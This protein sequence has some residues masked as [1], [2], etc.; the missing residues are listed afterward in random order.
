M[1]IIGGG[2][3]EENLKL[4]AAQV[5]WSNSEVDVIAF[6]QR[7]REIFERLG[8]RKTKEISTVKSRILTPDQV[9]EAE[10]LR[11]KVRGI[12]NQPDKNRKIY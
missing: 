12:L 8:Q 3:S 4:I 10:I 1:I 7:I 5:H 9:I 11:N 2:F 6:D